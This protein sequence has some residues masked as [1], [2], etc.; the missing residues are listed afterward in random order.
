MGT[1]VAP[2]VPMQENYTMSPL[3]GQAGN[4]ALARVERC[5]FLEDDVPKLVTSNG[6]D[7]S[8]IWVTPPMLPSGMIG[9]TMSKFSSDLALRGY[10]PF[11]LW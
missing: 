1:S 3:W 7:A 5:C 8:P 6:D 10:S 11:I 9:L 2:I 4:L